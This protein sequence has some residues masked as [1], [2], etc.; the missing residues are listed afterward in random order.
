MANNIY[1]KN[2]VCPRCIVAVSRI[3]EDLDIPYASIKLGEV[4]LASV[5]SLKKK[6]SM[7]IQLLDLG[8]SLIN[9]RKSQLIEQMKG[10][11]VEKVHHSDSVIGIKWAEYIS[12]KLNTNVK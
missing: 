5:L 12:Y 9:D 7:S 11:V 2:M 10:L 4:E 8:F 3:L 6:N 1:V